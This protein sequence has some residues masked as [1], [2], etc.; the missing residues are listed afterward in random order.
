VAGRRPQCTAGA[1]SQ[2]M[3]STILLHGNI[4][5][6]PASPGGSSVGPALYVFSLLDPASNWGC[7]SFLLTN[8]LSDNF[9]LL[10]L[11]SLFNVKSSLGMNEY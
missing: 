9:I 5:S 4:K 11:T 6:A 7:A 2:G 1:D 8:D 3:Y 10:S